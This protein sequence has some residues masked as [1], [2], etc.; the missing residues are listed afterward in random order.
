MIHPLS[1]LKEPIRSGESASFLLYT[2]VDY[3]FY[4]RLPCAF[5]LFDRFT[6]V[7]EPDVLPLL[8]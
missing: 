6:I 4:E 8:W 7:T 2:D 3:F 1:A 5:V